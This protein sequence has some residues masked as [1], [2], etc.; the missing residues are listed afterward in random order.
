[1]IN[2]LRLD[3]ACVNKRNRTH[4]LASLSSSSIIFTAP[5]VYESGTNYTNMLCWVIKRGIHVVDVDLPSTI[6]TE[7]LKHLFRNSGTNLRTIF[8]QSFPADK[9]NNVLHLIAK[10]CPNLEQLGLVGSILAK[11]VNEVFGA[12]TKLKNIR[13]EKN[14]SFEASN[15]HG[16]MCPS[17][18]LVSLL[19]SATNANILA[20]VKAFPNALKIGV[21]NSPRFTDIGLNHI[22]QHCTL[23]QEVCLYE[24]SITESSVVNLAQACRNLQVIDIGSTQA[25]DTAVL[26][27]AQHC[28]SLSALYADNNREL[29]DHALLALSQYAAATL[30]VLYVTGCTQISA[31]GIATLLHRAK[32]LHTLSIG[33]GTAFTT[34]EL[35]NLASKFGGLKTLRLRTTWVED[36][37]LLRLSK[38]AAAALVNLDLTGCGGIGEEGLAA[39]ALGLRE[40]R[41]L[42]FADVNNR[43][44]MSFLSKVLWKQLRPGLEISGNPDCLQYALIV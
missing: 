20:V 28:R 24:C 2:I 7:E 17:V 23:L 12:C 9:V 42:V 18:H 21:S 40:L 31:S 29:T 33:E 16:V 19:E 36:R 5:L 44:G 11:A 38:H 14:S 39:L 13:F 8:L 34:D 37:V 32:S 41:L 26:T 6:K 10:F 43:A 22:A 25:G 27:L 4:L 15:L 30:K 3:V 1:M 35:V